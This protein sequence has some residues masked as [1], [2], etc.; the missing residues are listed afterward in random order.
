MMDARILRI[1]RRL[2]ASREEVFD[3]WID[4]HALVAWLCAGET[5]VTAAEVDPRVGGRFR[6][7]MSSG[8]D[9]V[10]HSGEY[11]EIRRPERL[12]FT[13]ASKHTGGRATLVTVTFRHVADEET[14]LTLTHEE[15]PDEE[16]R[17]KH[18][19]GWRSI[20][21]KL[22]RFLRSGSR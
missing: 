3:A 22:E 9:D 13:W 16:A 8:Q 5:T 4:R 11:R 15:L 14:E 1:V 10:E 12:V 21:E 17:R 19:W 18:D 20:V 6:I 2:P 7:V